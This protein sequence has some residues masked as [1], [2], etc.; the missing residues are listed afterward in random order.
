MTLEDEIEA[1]VENFW[2]IRASQA[3]SA[4]EDD[5]PNGRQAVTG[6]KHLDA[7]INLLKD[8]IIETGVNESEVLTR[9]NRK[10]PGY[11]RA[12]KDWDLI[13]VRK[14][15]LLAVIEIK[16]QVGS[17]GNNINN[18]AEEALGN[19]VDLQRAQV[20]GAFGDTLAPWLGY[21]FVLEER[22][23]PRGSTNP[24]RVTSPHFPVFAEFQDASYVD[25]I[26][27]LCRR[28]VSE[29]LYTSAWYLLTKPDP[30]YR[31]PDRQLS[32]EVFITALQGH[33]RAQLAAE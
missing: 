29:K 16:S 20:H 1:A 10:I 26:G 31:H 7:F 5:A 12:T 3:L 4:G 27:E 28:L 9:N 32:A 33:L 18:R 13:V 24:V 2:R 11:F 19:A 6:G 17:F 25:R 15:R 21:V 8:K 23:G 14:R 30:T 22:D